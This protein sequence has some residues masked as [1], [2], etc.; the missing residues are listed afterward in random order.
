MKTPPS[1]ILLD[2]N[3]PR[4]NGFEFLDK[5]CIDEQQTRVITMLTSSA[6]KQ[7]IEK[8]M[9]YNCVHKYSLKPLKAEDLKNLK[10]S[11]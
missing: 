4:M 8:A 10:N 2:I 5:Y 1:L 6:Q 3:M 7:D 9:Q 11:L